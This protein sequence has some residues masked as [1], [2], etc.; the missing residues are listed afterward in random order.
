M[1]VNHR[2][3]L[4][5]SLE[6]IAAGALCASVT[7]CGS[8]ATVAKMPM[9]DAEVKEFLLQSDTAAMLA[10]NAGYAAVAAAASAQRDALTKAR[11]AEVS[12]TDITQV[13]ADGE[14]T[15]SG[16]RSRIDALSGRTLTEEYTRI[17]AALRK[18]T[19]ALRGTDKQAITDSLAALNETVAS[20]E[21]AV[22][23]RESPGADSSSDGSR[24]TVEDPR[25]DSGQEGSGSG[26]ATRRSEAGNNG[27]AGGGRADDGGSGADNTHGTGQ[28]RPQENPGG[29]TDQG[30]G[31]LVPGQ[32]GQQPPDNQPNPPAD[33]GGNNNQPAPAD[34]GGDQGGN[35]NGGNDGDNGGNPAQP[36]PQPGGGEAPRQP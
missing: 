19:E 11:G 13:K 22:S 24:T 33:G 31:Q 7:A 29:G 10:D 16:L 28:D 5:N 6:V 14:V 15:L 2:L 4:R 26:G 9:T 8:S 18:A 17:Q 32:G 25:E 35:G 3:L 23:Q 12:S 36:N 21:N 30:G 1:R 27:Q 20:V 34:P